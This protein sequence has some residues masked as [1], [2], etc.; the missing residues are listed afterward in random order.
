[1]RQ[2]LRYLICAVIM[3]SVALRA[4]ASPAGDD[5]GGGKVDVKEI[6][7]SHLQDSY[8]WHVTMIGGRHISIP[9]PV[10]LYSKG[11]GWHVFSSA[12][13]RHGEYEGFRIASGGRYEGKIVEL[14]AAGEYVRPLDI[15]ITKNALALMINGLILVAVVLGVAR[16]YS[17]RPARSVPKG[18]AGAFEMFVMNIHDDVIKP[19]IGPDYKR[20]APYLLTAFFFIFINNVMGLIP[21][22]PG[23]AS[24]TGNIAVTL[25][26]A[27]C[28]FIAINFW[29]DR[30]Y[31]KEV[32]WPDVPLWMKVPVPLMPAIE[33]F[34]VFTKPFALMIRLFANIFAG[35]AVILGLACIIFVTASIDPAI[36]A[37]MSVI[38][39][40]MAILM[41]CLELLIAYIQA[42]VFTML[43]AVFIGLS[44]QES[45]HSASKA[46]SH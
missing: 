1:M 23:G 37:G 16:W 27:V 9:L 41:N 38:S 3:T 13:L 11:T 40:I 21:F 31:W 30:E 17:R 25:V 43:S 33:L 18:F 5:T 22:F 42:Y 44:R 15:S 4:S 28:T 10:I 45:Q 12:H 19:C 2:V 14:D 34:G 20:Y 39:V 32:F 35:H 36:N 29:G 24:T 8:E 46:K 7:F 26:L 6:I